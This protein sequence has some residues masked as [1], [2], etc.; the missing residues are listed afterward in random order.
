VRNGE[1]E[2]EKVGAFAKR[3]QSKRATLASPEFT[4]YSL[5]YRPTIN[6]YVLRIRITV[7]INLRISRSSYKAI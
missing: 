7:N 6:F 2:I 3:Q 5:H 1:V 4:I